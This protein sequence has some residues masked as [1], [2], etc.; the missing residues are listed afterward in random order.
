MKLDFE[1]EIEEMIVSSNASALQYKRQVDK[2]N[3]E[4]ADYR[5]QLHE[6]QVK[7]LSKM[8]SSIDNAVKKIA[9]HA[10][11][12]LEKIN[13]EVDKDPRTET[14]DEYRRRWQAIRFQIQEMRDIAW[15]MLDN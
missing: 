1:K 11:Q 2:A 13:A 5:I 7:E 10:A 15:S 12:F 9:N 3:Q 14:T 6:W 4:I 8:P